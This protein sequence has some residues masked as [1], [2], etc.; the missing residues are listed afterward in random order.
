MSSHPDEVHNHSVNT[1]FQDVLA[2]RLQRREV[3]R[4]GVTLATATTLSSFALVGC[5]DDDDDGS[6]TS[7]SLGFNA[8]AKNLDD[9]VT[10]PAGY[11]AAVLYAFGDPID[12]GTPAFLNNGTDTASERRAGDQHDGMAYFGLSDAGQWEPNR[13]DRGLLV[14]NHEQVLDQYIHVAGPTEDLNGNR[15]QAE[16]DKEMNAHGVSVI[17]VRRESGSNRMSYVQASSFNRRITAFTEM[18]ITGPA[19]GSARLVTPFSQGGT[20]TR[21]TLNNCANGRTPWGTYF[22]CE[23]NWFSYWR[24]DDDAALRNAADNAQLE[25]Y[26]MG[27]GSTGFSYRK[28]D[29]VNADVYRRFNITAQQGGSA[30]TDYRN[31]ANTY[32]YIVEIDPFNPGSRPQKR[33][34]LGRFV[35]EGCWA[36]PAI[37]GRP[38]VFYMGDDNRFDYIYKFVSAENWDPAAD[39][40][41]SDRLAVGAK[42]LDNGTLYVARFNADGSGD[43]LELTVN[44]N[45]LDINNTLFPFA[46]QADVCIATRLAA[47]SVGATKMDRPEWGTVN[48]V[49]GE[50][51]MTLTNNTRRTADGATDAANPRNYDRG[52]GNADLD[53]NVNGHIIRWRETGGAQEAT[54][55]NWD[56]YLFGA[57]ADADPEKINVSGLVDD[58]DFSSP[59][60]LWFDSRGVLWIQTD[61]GEFPGAGRSNNQMLAALPGQVG[62]GA[63]VSSTSTP[64]I[65]G[66]PA[67]VDKVRRFLVGPRGCEITGIDMTPDYRTM[68]VNI[69]HPGEDGSLT[70]PDGTWPNPNR[71]ALSAGQAGVRPRSATIVIYRDD[72]GEIGV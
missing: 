16:V 9:A 42:Y 37:A 62:D 29:T 35:H 25:R 70:E 61:D 65:A 39:A 22:A 30:T 3:L 12:A 38:L 23:E 7:R 69:Q 46:S 56:I 33:T 4:G 63:V 27:P 20:R 51:Y 50:V 60:G 19:R 52:A 26:G 34:A 21:G 71:N 40:N 17:E 24:R 53:G 14:L 43:W 49:N 18:D 28:W 66:A 41:P 67:T 13:S 54:S 36:A 48:P 57:R 47:D 10:L 15:P 58:N 72:G 44:K 31:E 68:F 11:S 64:T 59:D 32:G 5:D 55:F 8:V 6:N 1:S 2:Q 45:G